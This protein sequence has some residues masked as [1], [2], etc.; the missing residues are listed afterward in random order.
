MA[1]GG[2]SV[3]Q[4]HLEA[5]E[6]PF[7]I[8]TIY[9]MMTEVSQQDRDYLQAAALSLKT[10]KQFENHIY[11]KLQEEYPDE[12]TAQLRLVANRFVTFNTIY[13]RTNVGTIAAPTPI[14]RGLD[15]TNE[16]TPLTNMQIVQQKDLRNRLNEIVGR[17][18]T[19]CIDIS[20]RAEEYSSKIFETREDY[21]EAYKLR[22]KFFT[23][24][25]EVWQQIPTIVT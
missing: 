25:N 4:E 9:Q 14:T 23:L 2:I 19:Q 15:V 12:P 3:T 7:D 20:E 11:A 24:T 16:I 1:Q 22:M 18:Y 17:L 10:D 5:A 21:K 13:L 8:K 6:R